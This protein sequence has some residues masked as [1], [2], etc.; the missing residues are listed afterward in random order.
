ML[1]I[2]PLRTLEEHKMLPGMPLRT[3]GE[4]WE[5][6]EF[7]SVLTVVK[8]KKKPLCMLKGSEALMTFIC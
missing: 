1:P 2:V 4:Q 7:I 6:E 8:K 3:L 5:A